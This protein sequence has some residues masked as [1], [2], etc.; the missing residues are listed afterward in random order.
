MITEIRLNLTCSHLKLQ[1]ENKIN[2]TPKSSFVLFYCHCY[3]FTFNW[4]TL[5]IHIYKIS[6]DFQCMYTV[7]NIQIRVISICLTT[8]TYHYF[9]LRRFKTLL[10][11]ILKCTKENDGQGWSSYFAWRKLD[12]WKGWIN[13]LELLL[14]LQREQ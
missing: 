11:A 13:N 6:C 12:C 3:H 8:N 10:Q 1:L 5:I 2:H 4:S 9:V 14:P 7:H